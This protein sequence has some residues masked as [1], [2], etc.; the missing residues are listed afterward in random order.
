M[1]YFDSVS[2][3]G[4][5]RI[6]ANASATHEKQFAAHLINQDTEVIF[7]DEWTSDS[8]N[9]EES[10]PRSSA[11]LAP[12]KSKSMPTLLHICHSYHYECIARLWPSPR[13]SCSP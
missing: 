13:W 5:M 7:L 11:N 10:P 3:L 4:L 12:E 1:T 8:L 9:A 6:N 2:I